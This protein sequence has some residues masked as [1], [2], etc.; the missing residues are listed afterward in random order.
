MWLHARAA[1]NALPAG[2]RGGTG[3]LRNGGAPGGGHK[4]S[5][6]AGTGG[7]YD[8]SRAVRGVPCL[9]LLWEAASAVWHCSRERAHVTRLL[10]KQDFSAMTAGLPA[11]R[12]HCIPPPSVG[13]RSECAACV[14]GC[15][16]LIAERCVTRRSGQAHVLR[17]HLQLACFSSLAPCMPQRPC[18]FQCVALIAPGRSQGSSSERA[19]VSA[20]LQGR[21]V[22]CCRSAGR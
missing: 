11:G 18:L 20:E 1:A 7:G 5:A 8:G 21:E 9:L 15:Y 19:R 22:A 2:A 14:Q 12:Q 17:T 4:G 13:T 16:R 10:R 3:R 6:S